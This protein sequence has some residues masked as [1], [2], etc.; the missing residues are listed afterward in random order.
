VL[1]VIA[2]HFMRASSITAMRAFRGVGSPGGPAVRGLHDAIFSSSEYSIVRMWARNA[3]SSKN[4]PTV[5]LMPSI[6]SMSTIA[7]M[8]C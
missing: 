2:P 6:L 8:S 5:A 1:R 3:G 7:T 4:A